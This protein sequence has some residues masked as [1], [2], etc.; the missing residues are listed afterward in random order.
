MTTEIYLDANATTAVLP[1]AANAALE[2]MCSRFGNPSSSHGAGLQARA[3]LETVRACAR[4]VIGAGH[5]RLMFNSG[6]TEGIQTAMLS[7]LV[8]LRDRRAAGEAIGRWL[9]VGATEHKAVPESLAHW[10]RVLG[11][12]LDIVV[13]E[14]GQDGRHDLAQLRRLAPDA[15]LVCTMAANNETGVT[16]NLA[17][18]EAALTDSAAYWLVDC[19]QALGKLG[20]DLQR[21]RIDY[22]PFSGHK[23]YAPKGIGMLY[24][25]PGA[26]FT[27]LMVGGGQESGQRSGTE[28]M[29]GIAALGEVLAALESGAVFSSQ[30]QLEALRGQLVTSLSAAFPGIVFNAPSALALP[31]TINFSVP[32]LSSRELLDLFDAAELSVSTGSACSAAKAEPSFVLRAMALPAWQTEAA[33]RL[34]FGPLASEREIAAACARIAHCGHVVRV[35]AML[36]PTKK[37]VEHI[38]PLHN[39]VCF[40]HDGRSSWLVA[41]VLARSCVLIDVHNGAAT[42][43]DRHVRRHGYRIDAMLETRIEAAGLAP[44]PVG[45]GDYL[46]TPVRH[47][48]RHVIY[49]LTRAGETLIQA[50]HAFIGQIAARDIAPGMVGQDTLLLAATDES[51]RLATSLRA[52]HAGQGEEANELSAAMTGGYLEAHPNARLIDVRELHE[53]LAGQFARST[54]ERERMAE[55]VPLS[56]LASALHDWLAAPETPLVF[57]CRSGNRSARAAACLRRLGHPAAWSIGG[58]MAAAADVVRAE[59]AA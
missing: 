57:Y 31:T 59:R 43:I 34:S 58:G 13:L 56:H 45:F 33:I 11:L 19:V 5:G 6:A 21:T 4:R 27:P 16:S 44:R 22:A 14:V 36:P 51:G 1:A 49:V 54:G 41:D 52:E 8:A 20:L 55:H 29:S 48:G 15:C 9:V 7:A 30:Q 37:P 38:A 42:P 53:Q 50:S 12:D 10:N 24:V 46:L 25:R 2:T 39:V 35:S 28:N 47:G 17:G 3:L 40:T 26:P 32:W 23:L 18:I